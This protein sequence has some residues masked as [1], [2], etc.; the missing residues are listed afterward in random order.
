MAHLLPALPIIYNMPWMASTFFCC[1]KEFPKCFQHS[2][3][4]TGSISVYTQ[5]LLTDIVSSLQQKSKKFI[6]KCQITHPAKQNKNQERPQLC[7]T[8]LPC[9]HNPIYYP[10]ISLQFMQ[11]KSKP[12]LELCSVSV[13]NKIN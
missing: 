9:L 10:K 8:K 6:H 1:F 2:A 12:A 3:K 4:G 11:G 13:I 5:I 7:C